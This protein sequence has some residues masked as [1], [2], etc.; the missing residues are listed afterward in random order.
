[1][2][3]SVPKSVERSPWALPHH[4]YHSGIR[5]LPH[6]PQANTLNKAL[7]T[8]P[9]LPSISGLSPR[10]GGWLLFLFLAQAILLI[11]CRSLASVYACCV[12]RRKFTE[13]SKCSSGF[14]LFIIY[15][16]EH[17]TIANNEG[18]RGR[19]CFGKDS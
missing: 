14:F 7:G 2:Q 8:G 15:C 17:Q 3:N 16:R 18:G 10:G 9:T 1:M 6:T 5:R 4:P 12:V 11:V 19:V 13:C